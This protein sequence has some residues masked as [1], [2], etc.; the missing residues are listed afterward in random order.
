MKCNCSIL[1]PFEAAVT[2]FQS[3]TASDSN[4]RHR[5]LA[6]STLSQRRYQD[7]LLKLLKNNQQSRTAD[8]S[9]PDADLV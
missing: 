2:T 7:G 8:L 4:N 3:E 6:A 1:P 9:T 5:S